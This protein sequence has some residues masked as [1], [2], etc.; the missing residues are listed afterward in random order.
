MKAKRYISCILA[1]VFLFTFTACSKSEFVFSV[2]ITDNSVV[3]EKEFRFCAAATCGGEICKTEVACNGV[4]LEENN[5]QYTARLS[6]G[7]NVIEVTAICKNATETR[8]Y[9]VIYR[10]EFSITTDIGQTVIKNDC[11]VFG[12]VATFNDENCA[13]AVT[14]NGVPVVEENGVYTVRLACG[15]NKFVI[16]ARYGDHIE[17]TERTIFYEG[18][19][20]NTD[21]KDFDTADSNYFFRAAATY[22]KQVCNLTVTHNGKTLTGVGARYDTELSKGDNDIV[23]TAECGEITKEYAYT[24][25]YFD[26]PP[27]LKTSIE[28]GKIYRG[29]IFNFDVTANDGLG[30]KLPHENI[31]FAVD[32]DVDD[33]KEQFVSVNGISTVWDDDTATSY[34]IHF[35]K[36]DFANHQNKAFVLKVTASDGMGRTSSYRYAM[37]YVPAAY[38]EEI[39]KVVF[40]MEGFSVSC[41]YFIKPVWVSIREGIPFSV[42]LT[43]LLTQYGYTYRYTGEIQSGFYLSQVGGLDLTGNSIAEGIWQRVSGTYSRTLPVGSALGEFCYGSGSGWM[44]SVN[45]VYKNYGF[46]DYYPQDGD[47]VRVQFTVMLGEDLGGGGALGGGGGSYLDD[48]PDY[49][50]IMK[51]LADFANNGAEDETVYLQVTE[52]ITEW[53]ISQA[54][55]DEQIAKFKSAYG[56][57]V[58]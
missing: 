5:G 48:N 22:G 43:D 58:L 12:A 41:G 55:M 56:E 16:T 42:T 1:I 21:I 18:F 10:A 11:A 6:D 45:G 30:T 37:T 52:A 34:R 24:I 3:T 17:Q 38:G 26:D 57:K 9:S 13:V 51:L 49:A 8:I 7:N 39:G 25:R 32:W 31:A 14:N 46:S 54:A 4:L 28:S 19:A 20:L 29:S 2:N 36:G 50:P 44:Y 35:D 47:A 23:I 40:A 15:E 33:G 53:N 27:A